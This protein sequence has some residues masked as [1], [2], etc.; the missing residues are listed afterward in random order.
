VVNIVVIAG[1]ELTAQRP[2]AALFCSQ[3]HELLE[4][5]STWTLWPLFAVDPRSRW[6]RGNAVLIGDAAHAMAPSAA[7]GG[8]QAIEDAWVLARTLS[9]SHGDPT[10]ALSSYERMRRS[11]VEAIVHES[12][13]N[14]MIYNSTGTFAAGRNVILKALPARLLLSRLDWVFG[15]KAE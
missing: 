1:G 3:A 14:L 12:A 10:A 5:V 6:T 15:W 8:G 13:R 4:G 7:Q 11:R 2:S 9:A